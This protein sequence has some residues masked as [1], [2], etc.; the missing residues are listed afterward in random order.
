MEKQN[1]RGKTSISPAK[2]SLHLTRILI[3]VLGF[4]GKS[5]KVLESTLS[6]V[7]Y[8]YNCI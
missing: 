5:A 6:R 8:N 2:L 4:A 7:L 1:Y 3:C